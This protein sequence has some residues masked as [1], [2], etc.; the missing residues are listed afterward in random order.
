[1]IDFRYI[2]LVSIKSTVNIGYPEFT[3]ICD[4]VDKQNGN[5]SNTK[6]A[7]G[8]VAAIAYLTTPW[9]EAQQS[10]TAKAKASQF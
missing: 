8:Y 1:M 10:V 6:H 7:T 9:S 5:I 3:C 2:Y 4:R